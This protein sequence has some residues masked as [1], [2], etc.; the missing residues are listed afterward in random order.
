MEQQLNQIF[1]DLAIDK[2]MQIEMMEIA[3]NNRNIE[4]EDEGF[5]FVDLYDQE[6]QDMKL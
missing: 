3:R 5:S 2:E 6:F 1:E 4:Q